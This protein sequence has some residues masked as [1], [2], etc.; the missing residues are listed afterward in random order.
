[1]KNKFK[2]A[3]LCEFNRT[4]SLKPELL[5]EADMEHLPE[6]VKK[7]LR[8]TG[9]AGKEKILNFRAEY[10][11]GIRFSPDEEY[12][13]LR[14]VQYNFMDQP[15]RLFYIVAKKKG[16]PAVGLHIYRNVKAIFKI[17]ILGLFTVVDASGPEMDQ[18][19]TVTVLNDMFFIAPGSLIDKRIQWETIN[20]LTVKATF[21][22]ENIS[23]SAVLY[24]HEDGRLMNFISND[25]YETNGREYKN[26]PWETP[27]SEYKE[28]NGYRLPSKARLI[29]RRPEGDFCYGEFELVSIEYN[30]RY[31]SGS[32]I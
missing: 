29:Y 32:R 21:T 3:V 2:K 13:P 11:G 24:F 14:S 27:V 31:R 16:I 28:A 12:M 17:K 20:D 10:K 5:T 7:Y 23:I 6:S 30:C 15:A 1:M 19:E 22:N 8:Y 9:F 25:R 4:E 26:Y 18:G